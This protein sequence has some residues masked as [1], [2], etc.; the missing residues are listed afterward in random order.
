MEFLS[1]YE[2]GT[3][4]QQQQDMTAPRTFLGSL[5]LD[6]MGTRDPRQRDGHG[7]GAAGGLPGAS[8]VG[9]QQ[10]EGLAVRGPLPAKPPHGTRRKVG[11]GFAAAGDRSRS[12][13]LWQPR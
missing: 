12:G 6:V 4:F 8:G 2:G 13:A 1:C 7:R 5:V 10:Q 3:L 9:C 11:C